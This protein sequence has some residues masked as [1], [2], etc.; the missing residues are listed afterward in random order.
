MSQETITRTPSLL[1]EAGK[2]FYQICGDVDE[3]YDE[4]GV[5]ID[6]IN[7]EEYWLNV[8]EAAHEKVANEY[9]STDTEI[10]KGSALTLIAATPYYLLSQQRLNAARAN[11]PTARPLSEEEKYARTYYVSWFN[12]L[13]RDYALLHPDIVTPDVNKSLTEVIRKSDIT[14]HPE[15]FQR[16]LAETIRGAQHELAAGQVFAA[17]SEVRY[18][19]TEEDLKGIDLVMKHGRA[20]IPIDIKSSS[21]ATQKATGLH[22]RDSAV[23]NGRIVINIGM[24]DEDLQGRFYLP[25]K[26]VDALAI[27][28]KHT[29]ANLLALNSINHIEY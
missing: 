10:T 5:D 24:T 26:R 21:A 8:A 28:T 4:K 3:R 14:K 22:G 13:I 18:S 20:G 29:V 7:P 27:Q 15:A 9:S 19:T 12:G 25:Q 2:D 17:F 1:E 6:D 16:L 11:H 23:I